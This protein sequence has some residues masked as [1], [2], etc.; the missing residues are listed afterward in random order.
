MI[1]EKSC[2]WLVNASDVTGSIADGCDGDNVRVGAWGIAKTGNNGVAEAGPRGTAISGDEGVS[3]AGP[4][5]TAVTGRDGVAIAGEGGFAKAGAGGH[6]VIAHAGGSV[7]GQ[8]GVDFEADVFYRVV[9]FV[10]VK[11]LGE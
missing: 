11:R 6:I 9:D 4:G 1:T 3:K 10:L 2:G 5:G 7:V 8:E